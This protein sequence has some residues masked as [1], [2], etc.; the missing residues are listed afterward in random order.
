[1]N[2]GSVLCPWC[3]IPMDYVME[4]ERLGGERRLA[5]YYQC[6]ACRAKILD[7]RITIK[8]TAASL[9]V[10]VV[11]YSNGPRPTISPARRVRAK[12]Q[13]PIRAPT[14]AGSK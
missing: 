13:R 14:R 1:M 9:L 3:R 4:S 11:D 12:S 7:E 2:N 10:R 6:P 5:R 8:A